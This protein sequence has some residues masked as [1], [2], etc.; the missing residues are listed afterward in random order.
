MRAGITL[1][2]PEGI[3]LSAEFLATLGRRFPDYIL[4][5]FSEVPNYNHSYQK[6][7]DSIY[8]A[9]NYLLDAYPLP[10][11]HT[12]LTQATLKSAVGEYK[13]AY[14]G[15]NES[16]RGLQDELKLFTSKVIGIIC[17]AYNKSSSDAIELLNQAE[18]Y[19]LMTVGRND[20]VTVTPV[21][22][23]SHPEIKYFLQ[24]D[25]Y[26]PPYSKEILDELA[27][28][29]AENYPKT[30]DWF[31]HFETTE[32]HYK[33]AYF[34]NLHPEHMDIRRDFAEF[35]S[36]WEQVKETALDLKSDL[37][38]IDSGSSPLPTWFQALPIHQ[39]EMLKLLSN[40]WTISAIDRNLGD[41]QSM[42]SHG[43]YK[44]SLAQFIKIPQWYWILSEHQQYFL[45]HLL[46]N[47]D[48]IEEAIS[49]LSSRN[50]RLPLPANWGAHSLWWLKKTGESEPELQPVYSGKY[51][52]SHIATRDD[53]QHLPRAVQR[54][55]VLANLSKVME[56]A[57]PSQLAL[58]QTLVSPI[59][60]PYF[61]SFF[62]ELP[63]SHLNKMARL[64]IDDS[65]SKLQI[66]RTN[67]PLN[68][69]KYPLYTAADDANSMAFIRALRKYIPSV[70]GLNE[71]ITDYNEVLNSGVFT[72]TFLDYTGRELFLS[73]LEQ[74]LIVAVAGFSYGSCVSGKDRKAI[75]LMHTDAMRVYY[76]TYG[77]WP[78]FKDTESNRACFVSIVAD[79]FITHHH[80]ELAGSN[81]PGSEGI[82]TPDTYF[83][84]DIAEEINRRLKNTNGLK[85]SDKLA[86]NNEI[87]VICKGSPSPVE[88]TLLCQLVASQLGDERCKKLYQTL[89]LIVGQQSLFAPVTNFWR[90]SWWFKPLKPTL[91]HGIQQIINLMEAKDARTTVMRMADIF[92]IVL[93][94][95]EMH[96]SRSV[97]TQ[98]LYKDIRCLLSFNEKDQSHLVDEIVESWAA[99]FEQSKK[100]NCQ[101]RYSALEGGLF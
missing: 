20:L 53:L 36:V 6:R 42:I 75:E 14:D 49:V 41:F 34:C 18:Q 29:K 71:L 24:V 66:I 21:S 1:R 83:P 33:Q 85:W 2:V 39:R 37:Q 62:P 57:E 3:E 28:I 32:H 27:I 25:E 97:A 90:S 13:A 73:S 88:D 65:Q 93:Q 31:R 82:K 81:A 58:F 76:E 54:R 10:Q 63:D 26:L 84:A 19:A 5:N 94:R 55:H 51:R 50:R 87:R 46:K 100:A 70:L 96:W 4:E 35:L 9:F 11:A 12:P 95:S 74:L 61:L 101:S 56:F 59:E 44:E 92:T 40:E 16:V 77:C 80:E 64:V 68:M 89:F 99:L 23:E 22:M 60:I 72:A 47:K 30:P 15:S 45:E 17:L 7:V 8:S 86:S 48:S 98:S 43:E 79:F 69:A 52:S 78:K 38:Q 91:P 67:H